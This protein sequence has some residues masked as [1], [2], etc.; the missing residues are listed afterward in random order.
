MNDIPKPAAITKRM[1][2]FHAKH[3]GNHAAM[4]I[5]LRAE[6]DVNDS[7]PRLAQLI[8]LEEGREHGPKMEV[9]RRLCLRYTTTLA[10]HINAELEGRID[11]TPE[12]KKEE[13][14]WA[15]LD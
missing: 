3:C 14:T 6:P 2:E 12:P 9:L 13:E 5:A 7:C 11:E 1:R 4:G 15:F 10:K 8:T